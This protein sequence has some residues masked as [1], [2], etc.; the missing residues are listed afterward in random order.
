VREVTTAGAELR[1]A[2]RHADTSLA[3]T[4]W[5][6]LTGGITDEIHAVSAGIA[7]LHSQTVPLLPSTSHPPSSFHT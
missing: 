5:G 4:D 7:Y 3:T 1:S 6:T 2:I